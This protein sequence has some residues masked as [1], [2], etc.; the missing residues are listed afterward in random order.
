[1]M[2][3]REAEQAVLDGLLDEARAG[4]SGALVLRGQPGIGKSA[5]L[6][7]AVARA[8][9]LRVL[10]TAGI[11]SEAELPF[12]GLHLLLGPV[13]DR[14]DVLPERQAA[15]LRS[16]FGLGPA[17]QDGPLLVGL[18]VLSLLADLA[19]LLCVVDDAQWLDQASAEA[20]TFAARR[21]QRE[22][23]VLLFAVRGGGRTRL[24][25]MRELPLWGLDGRASAA[26]IAEHAADLAGHVR[27]RVLAESEG[28]P[29]AIIELPAALTPEQR[30][31][32]IPPLSYNL[33]AL[34]LTDRVRRAFG[35]QAAR[36]DEGTRTL[37]LVAAVE[38]AGDLDVVLRAAGALGAPPSALEHAE[39][40]GLLSFTGM[41]AAFK[42][43]LVRAAV[44]QEA[45]LARRL[46]AHRALA[47]ALGEQHPDRRAWHLAAA[48]TG[49]D[50]P[51]AAGLADT[52]EQ[53]AAR[54]GY[55]AQTA[56]LERAAELTPDPA[57]QAGRL[58]GAAEA[59]LLAGDLARAAQIARRAGRATVDAALTAR[60]AHVR[61]GVEFERGSPLAAA[62]ILLTGADPIADRRP[63]EAAR[64]LAEAVRNSYFGGDPALARRAA[65]RLLDVVGETPGAVALGGLA[66]LMAG[67]PAEAM[68]RM[69]VLLAEAG[70]GGVTGTG[71]RVIA[72]AMGMLTGDD[73]AALAIY[74]PLVA[75]ARDTGQIGWLPNALEHLAVTEMFLGRRR[76][77]VV[78]AEEG[79]RLA[80]STGQLHRVD[81][82][83]CVLAWAAALAGDE[84]ACRSLA[85]PA[86][87]RARTAGIARTAAWGSMALALLDLGH[88][89]HAR[90]LDRLEA[91]SRGTGDGPL[92]LMNL[93][94]FAGDQVEAAVRAGQP[95][96]AD[97]ALARFEGWSVA[98][99]QPWAA[100]VLLRCRALLTTVEDAGRYF[101]E[102]VRAHAKGGR[103][104]ERAR[105]E[106][107]YGEWLRRA[108]RKAEAR[109]LLRPALE[110]FEGMG[111]APWAERAR[112][113]LRAT[114]EAGT[115]TRDDS[116]LDRLTPQELQVVRLAAQ[117]LSNRDIAAQLFLSPRTIGHH[118]YRAYPKLGVSSRSELPRLGL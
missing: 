65:D 85:E 43:P 6:E 118:L 75:D 23:V 3:G 35:A 33:G 49:P 50:E 63:A 98:S 62:A 21:V 96:R 20:L 112:A 117:G 82:L 90:A 5:L 26:L 74:E 79:V 70:R 53:A 102:A 73:E 19:P 100:G 41:A 61:A 1:M 71:E 64:M 7:Y 72:G 95:E 111:A 54:G 114:G 25:G 14:V 58:V 109:S 22:G 92:G 39:R 81:H 48:A 10:R 56:A 9:G 31:G 42:H 106:L 86:I 55:A 94:H 11:E 34:P 38:E 103:P 16:A 44:V 87:A 37:L 51:I 80:E 101:A 12:A 40:S 99:E 52:A 13:L 67:D 108:Q 88:G 93:V 28:N 57:R 32:A 46:A 59:A 83:R 77:A 89:R 24:D 107:L 36:L 29:L 78:H 30:G 115:S 45:P 91:A 116:A 84:D 47:E 68:P 110:T 104:F 15:A 60:L 4:R 97:E 113:E 76:D 27:D 66:R 105:T 17:G 69:R 8:D 2:V 18:A